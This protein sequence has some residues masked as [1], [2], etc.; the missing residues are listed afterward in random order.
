MAVAI[1]NERLWTTRNQVG[2]Q[3]TI[4]G[5]FRVV[6]DSSYPTGGEEWDLSGYFGR[7][8][9]IDCTPAEDGTPGYLAVV[10]DTNFASTTSIKVLMYCE[11]G[12]SGVNQALT[13]CANARQLQSVVLRALIVGT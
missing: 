5:T 8:F 7:V 10:N 3:Y 6:F 13:Q 9:H 12:N 4:W 11:G 1:T 2:E